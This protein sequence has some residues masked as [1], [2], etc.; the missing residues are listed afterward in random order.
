[1][2]IKLRV[3][4][5]VDES[6]DQQSIMSLRVGQEPVF[7]EWIFLR[8]TCFNDSTVQVLWDNTHN[9][10]EELQ[11]NNEEYDNT[12]PNADHV[13]WRQDHHDGTWLRLKF[14]TQ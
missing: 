5:I 14:I 2:W 1:M 12:Y 11:I 8:I 3:C 4:G 10:C 13:S 9:S 7:V 6:K